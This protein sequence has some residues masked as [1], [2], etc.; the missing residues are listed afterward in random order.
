MNGRT[1]LRALVACAA[2]IALL[3]G[4][5]PSASAI[6][7]TLSWSVY[8]KHD[9]V[10]VRF[11]YHQIPDRDRPYTCT[12]VV[13]EVGNADMWVVTYDTVEFAGVLPG[14]HEVKAN[15]EDSDG[16]MVSV[17]SILIDMP[18]PAMWQLEGTEHA[19]ID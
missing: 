1:I 13:D 7:T 3:A 18:G 12:A 19:L 11:N 2:P 9:Q 6:D 10:R 5:A 4:T 14:P 17:G 8:T 15:C 16:D